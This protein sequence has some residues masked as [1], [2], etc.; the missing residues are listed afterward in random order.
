MIDGEAATA[1]A[2]GNMPSANPADGARSSTAGGGE[3]PKDVKKATHD[4]ISDS[5][6]QD[7]AHD[8]DPQRPNEHVNDGH[9]PD[10]Y[11]DLHKTR[12]ELDNV[13]ARKRDAEW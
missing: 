4:L 10:D 2:G 9:P 1:P 5:L 13:E 6:L 12:E 7:H 8:N 3:Q 11:D